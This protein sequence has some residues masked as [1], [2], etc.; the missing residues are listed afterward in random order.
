MKGIGLKVLSVVVFV[1][2]VDLHQGCGRRYPHRP[3]HLLSLGFCRMGRSLDFWHA[4]AHCGM[5][6]GPK[7]SP[8][9]CV[10]GFVGILAMS[11]GFYGLVHSAAAGGDCDRLCHATARCR[12]RSNFLG[13]IVRL[14][15]WV[16]GVVGLSGCLS[17]P[18]RGSRC[19][20]KAGSVSAEAK[21]AVAVLLSASAR[22]QRR[23]CSCAS[24]CR[25]ERTHTIVLYFS[26]LGRG[27]SR[28]ADAAFGWVRAFLA[29]LR[30]P[31]DRRLLRRRRADPVTE[32]LSPRRY[33]DDRSLRIHV[34]SVLG[35]RHRLLPLRRCAHPDHAC[36]DGDRRRRGHLHSSTGASAGD[37]NAKGARKHVDA[38]GIKGCATRRVAPR[39]ERYR[40]R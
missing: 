20:T 14:Y 11:C 38:A 16:C 34:D 5:R 22:G 15:R 1:V 10:R 24:S 8:D 28:L 37:W 29:G 36:R 18:G 35:I 6:S 12:F 26:L 23:W 9:T 2:H 27:C 19:S 25:K 39:Q 13:E 21:G 17:S 7:I 33:V 31:D 3:D 40:P 4:V 30:S 32:K